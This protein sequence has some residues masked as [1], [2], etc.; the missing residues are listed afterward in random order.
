MKNFGGYVIIMLLFFIAALAFM[1]VDRRCSDM[2][3]TGGRIVS[4][5][6]ESVSAVV[7]VMA[8]GR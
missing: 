2:Y 7:R 8:D 5:D 6:S 4:E 1:E 3:G